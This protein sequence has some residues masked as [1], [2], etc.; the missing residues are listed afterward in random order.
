[1]V[2]VNIR[3]GTIRSEPIVKVKTDGK[4]EAS[5][6]ITD[7]TASYLKANT[8][9]VRAYDSLAKYI[10]KNLHLNDVIGLDGCLK[11][12]YNSK[13]QYCVCINPNSI[14]NFNCKTFVTTSRDKDAT[15][16]DNKIVEVDA[17]LPPID[18][19]DF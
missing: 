18:L 8:F 12:Y 7:K 11:S 19:K 16:N 1:M 15:E 3:I 17:S 2:Y 9:L 5:F 13:K 4:W 14:T 6:L 10:E